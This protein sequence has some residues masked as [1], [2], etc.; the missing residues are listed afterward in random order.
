MLS[1][2]GNHENEQQERVTTLHS[3]PHTD[4]RTYT[5]TPAYLEPVCQVL[6]TLI[7]N[8][9]VKQVEV[10]QGVVGLQV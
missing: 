5:T 6:R 2:G 8:V 7:A 3:R 1:G 9:V 4:S 10:L